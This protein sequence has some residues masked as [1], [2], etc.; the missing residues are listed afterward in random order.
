MKN[1]LT[2]E[3]LKLQSKLNEVEF[4]Y[5]ESNW[6]E[7][8]QLVSKNSIWTKYGSIFKA[9]LAFVAIVASV[10][11]LQE[12]YPE[13]HDK[14]S[15]IEDK[16]VTQPQQPITKTP[17]I[18]SES[19]NSQSSDYSN[20]SGETKVEKKDT[21]LEDPSSIEVQQKIEQLNAKELELA[22][23]P[24]QEKSV[25]IK[26]NAEKIEE[27]NLEVRAD[28]VYVELESAPC[29]NE[30]LKVK[31]VLK[32]ALTNENIYFKWFINKAELKGNGIQNS[33]TINS[34]G[35]KQIVVKAYFGNKLL[36]EGKN[37]FTVEDKL[38]LTFTATDLDDIFYD[39]NV[40]LKVDQPSAGTYI[41]YIDKKEKVQY[42]KETAWSFLNE[43]RY[44]MTLEHVSP[45]GCVNQTVKSVEMEK[46]FIEAFPNSFSPDNDGL[47]D[48]FVLTTLQ[49]YNFKNF[50]LEILN[51]KGEVVFQTNDPMEG[52]NGRLQNSGNLLENGSYAWL[53]KIENANGRKKTFS[54]K[55]KT[56]DF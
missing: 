54:G 15:N 47:N 50:K 40:N 44:N 12:F 46:D 36:S 8:E 56:F 52:W 38:D 10:V 33:F 9:T 3:E 51:P 13:E 11:L 24:I 55:I 37:D 29:L 43:G 22:Q 17:N 42:G 14:V 25:H 18:A 30:E 26:P 35:E 27:N 32:E 34:S 28:V 5:Q 7:M 21:P 39:Q 4:A 31:A 1:K 45:N 48:V 20:I 23:T 19:L 53:V 41:W 49:G 6:A 2:S 16:E